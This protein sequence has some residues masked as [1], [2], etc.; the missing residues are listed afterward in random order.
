MKTPVLSQGTI[1]ALV[2]PVRAVVIAVGGLTAM[3]TM[4][5]ARPEALRPDIAIR[6]AVD[7]G[8]NSNIRI[9]RDP[10]DNRLYVMRQN[11]T[12][13]RLDL[14]AGAAE[15]VYTAADHG[16]RDAVQGFAI[17]PDGA[18]Y[19]VWTARG[20]RTERMDTIVQGV[21]AGEGGRVWSVLELPFPADIP[22]DEIQAATESSVRVS[23]D[24]VDNV[25]YSLD[26]AGDI[27]GVFSQEV[28]HSQEEHGVASPGGFFIGADG[29]YYISSSTV[30]ELSGYNIATIARGRLD[31]VTGE[32]VWSVLAQ[33][34]PFPQG[35]DHRFNAIAI[36][37]DNRFAL[38]NSGA[39]T[40]H[41]EVQDLGGQFPGMR[42][43]PLTSCILRLPVDG[44]QLLLPAD[45]PS[46]R[47]AGYFFAD[48]LRN[49]FS[50]AFAPN[51]DLFGTENGPHRDMPEELNWIREGHHYGFPWR[52]GG[53]DNPRQF[54]DYDP[55]SDAFI[56][57]DVRDHYRNDPDFPPP[58]VPFTSPVI[59]RGPDADIFRDPADG[60]IKDASEV[61]YPLGTFTPHR[62]P[63][64]LVFD[65]EGALSAEFHADGFVLSWNGG[66]ERFIR[67]FDD[68]GEDLCHLD[69]EKRGDHYEARVTRLV[70]GFANP[71]DAAISGNRIYVVGTGDG[72]VW[73]VELPAASSTAVAGRSDLPLADAAL[74]QNYPNPFNAS[75]VIR[76]TMS[77]P[78]PVEL[79]IY[80]LAGQKIQT[81]VT[82]E[83]MAGTH[84]ARWDGQTDAGLPAGSGTYAYRLK[85]GPYQQA[86][87]LTL[88]R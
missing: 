63:L 35:F 38:V 56:P 37:P 16:A 26:A 6:Q 28:A 66:E 88:L 83:R 33:T 73:E 76:Y 72:I 49:A 74:D 52:L 81:L 75:T 25:L 22:L 39:R 5:A 17:G 60:V 55:A 18:F 54:A 79:V 21:V 61:G 85:A 12:I 8:T 86:R 13:S 69:L 87:L 68:P 11:G 47:D 46:L 14:A 44:D 51:G 45:E 10:L 78:G 2:R 29:T 32:R 82:G 40:D 1:R 34:A 4:A 43:V 19:V 64:G 58:P 41:G 48:G 15:V 80:N 20:G 24:P 50:L 77:H 9:A 59:N 70:A 62:S 27:V 3:A 53:Q 23:T 42:E 71:V 67:P 31:P 7:T 36:S 84:T 30:V 65:T 57:R